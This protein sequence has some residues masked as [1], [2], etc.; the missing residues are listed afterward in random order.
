VILALVLLLGNVA[1]AAVPQFEEYPATTEFHGTPAVPDMSGNP[2]ARQYRTVLRQSSMKGPDFAGHYTFV[3][4]G[5]GTSCALV[6]VVD[7]VDGKV[8]FPSGLRMIEWAGWWHDA[9]GPEY[10][11][12]SRLL[13]VRGRANTEDGPYG[14]SYFIWT[15]EDFKLLSFKK[16]DPGSPPK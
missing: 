9:Y 15:G 2:T 1:Q 12:D 13:V 7:A 6:A 8:R 3:R 4:I 16:Q 14:V 10:R 11:L 5:C